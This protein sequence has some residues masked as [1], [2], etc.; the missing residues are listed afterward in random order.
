MMNTHFIYDTALQG[1]HGTCLGSPPWHPVLSSHAKQTPQRV[2]NS[3]LT[4]FML[5]TSMCCVG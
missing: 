2:R 1:V 3:N 4:W 5:P